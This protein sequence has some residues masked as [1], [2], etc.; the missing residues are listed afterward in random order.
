MGRISGATRLRAFFNSKERK[1]K[2]EKTSLTSCWF[3]AALFV[4]P[5]IQLASNLTKGV[6]IYGTRTFS[7]GQDNLC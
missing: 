4:C 3:A 7:N 2:T 5:C 6:Q 1:G